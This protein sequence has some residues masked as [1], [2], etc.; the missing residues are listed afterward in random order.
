M[1]VIHIFGKKNLSRIYKE[2]LKIN[3]KKKTTGNK[4]DGGNPGGIPGTVA[5]KLAANSE[6]PSKAAVSTRRC[7]TDA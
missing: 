7:D 5:E 1:F 4:S 3:K 6:G 2:L